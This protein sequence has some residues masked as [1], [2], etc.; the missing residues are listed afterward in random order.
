MGRLSWPTPTR[1]RLSGGDVAVM[2]A[3]RENPARS[4][5]TLV[6]LFTLLKQRCDLHARGVRPGF[7]ED[8]DSVAVSEALGGAVVGTLPTSAFTRKGQ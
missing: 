7:G 2:R 6:I 8:R 5:N 1:H 3:A 4:C